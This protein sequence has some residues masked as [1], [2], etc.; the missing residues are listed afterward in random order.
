MVYQLNWI[1]NYASHSKEHSWQIGSRSKIPQDSCSP[2]AATILSNLGSSSERF[3]P[4]PL[5]LPLLLCIQLGFALKVDFGCPP[6]YETL[7]LILHKS[8]ILFAPP[9]VWSLEAWYVVQTCGRQLWCKCCQS[10]RHSPDCPTQKIRYLVLW[11][12]IYDVCEKIIS[13]HSPDCPAQN[14]IHLVLYLC[15]GYTLYYLV[16]D[17]VW[18]M[19]EWLPGRVYLCL[20]LPGGV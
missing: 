3:P 5:S 16:Y 20:G 6:Q 4:S 7:R 1:E 8:L 14:I 9:T 18:Y 11:C 12:V 13:P 10:P 2:G 19:Y 15:G 17:P